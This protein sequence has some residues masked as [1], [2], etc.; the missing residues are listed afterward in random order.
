MSQSQM[1]RGH[2]CVPILLTITWLLRALP[3]PPSRSLLPAFVTFNTLDLLR[4]QLAWAAKTHKPP[5]DPLGRA[6]VYK[7]RDSAGFPNEQ[8]AYPDC[9]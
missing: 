7:I 8:M 6:T 4:Q 2:S 1:I 3:R 9:Q 5:C